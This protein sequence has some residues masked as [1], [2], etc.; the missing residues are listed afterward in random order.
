MSAFHFEV[1]LL[2]TSLI[3]LLCLVATYRVVRSPAVAIVAALLKAGV[4]AAYFGLLFDGTFTFLD[5]IA[6]L[7]SGALLNA[8]EIGVSNLDEQWPFVM[9]LVG[10]Q[11]ILYLFHNAYAFQMF[12]EGYYAPVA[13]NVLITIFIAVLGARLAEK[14]FGLSPRSRNYF[15]ILLLFH[16]DILAWSTVANGKDTLVLLAH[17]SLLWSASLFFSGRVRAAMAV[18]VPVVVF[19]LFLRFYVP[20]LFLLAL[21]AVSVSARGSGRLKYM[22]VSM[23]ALAALITLGMRDGLLDASFK[24]LLD[25]FTNPVYGFIRMALTPVPF[26]TE[27]AYTFLNVPALLHW[28]CMPLAVVGFFKIQGYGTRFSKFFIAYLLMFLA[29]YAL[30]R[31]LQGPRHRYQMD[32]ALALMQYLGFIAVA[33][34]QFPF[35]LKEPRTAPT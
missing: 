27:V 15:Y 30:F 10:G 20:L 25:Q 19:L 32:Y 34:I 35:L 33:R 3:F 6:Y 21:V 12:G 9:S 31:E 23:V 1:L 14:E 13:L 17:V 18:A 22:A 2:P 29:L 26:N 5:D 8:R 4:Y 7:Q 24:I 11:H 16:P 28:I